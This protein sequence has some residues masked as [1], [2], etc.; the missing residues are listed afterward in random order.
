MLPGAELRNAGKRCSPPGEPRDLAARH[1]R[2][3][4]SQWAHHGLSGC[5]RNLQVA[6]HQV[7]HTS[8]THLLQARPEQPRLLDYLD[9]PISP[10]RLELQDVTDRSVRSILIDS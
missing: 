10:S 1:I 7:G 8:S 6:I 4:E 9:H 2:S 5:M 3:H